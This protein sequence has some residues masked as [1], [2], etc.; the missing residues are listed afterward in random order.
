M[1]RVA[2]RL[3]DDVENPNFEE[4][5]RKYGYAYWGCRKC[6]DAKTTEM[7]LDIL[8]EEEVER[9]Q[10]RRGS[11]LILRSVAHEALNALITR[12]NWYERRLYKIP[13]ATAEAHNALLD[14]LDD[15]TTGRIRREE[16]TDD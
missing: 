16:M 12:V 10:P 15:E 14:V 1:L 2:I 5:D 3:D 7:G 4:N 11:V 6:V 13:R 9:P 8:D